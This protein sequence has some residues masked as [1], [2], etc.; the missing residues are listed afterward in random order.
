MTTETRLTGYAFAI[1]TLTVVLMV[2]LIYLWIDGN[3]SLLDRLT[4]R[5]AET[6]EEIGLVNGEIDSLLTVYQSL[7]SE[8]EGLRGSI[9]SAEQ[10]LALLYS[11]LWAIRSRRTS[12]S[13][14]LAEL[15]AFKDQ[16][17]VSINRVRLENQ[18]LRA[19]SKRLLRE[20]GRATKV[21][22]RPAAVLSGID[23]ANAP[24]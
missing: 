20:L 7:A 5:A 12:L 21:K 18:E 11:T 23:L 9:P 22:A 8:N 17:L 16:L 15:R 6:D 10:A 13:Q 14:Q 2:S 3:S 1:T 4:N 19:E 24:N